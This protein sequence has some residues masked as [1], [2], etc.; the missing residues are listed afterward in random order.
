MLR[1]VRDMDGAFEYDIP[2]C[3]DSW[4]LFGYSI[5]LQINRRGTNMAIE[6]PMKLF[7]KSE[8]HYVC[9]SDKYMSESLSTS[10]RLFRSERG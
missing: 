3:Q 2:L 1:G 4:W 5:G 6:M 8:L 9:R 10:F 7:N